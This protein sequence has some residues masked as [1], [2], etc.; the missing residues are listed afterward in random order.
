[1]RKK[2]KIK[3]FFIGLIS[4]IVFLI[5]LGGISAI[6][7]NSYFLRM[8]PI[9]NLDW[10]LLVLT[11][12]LGGLYVGLYYYIKS[13]KNKGVSCATSGGIL[14]FLAFA[15]PVCNK[16]ILLIL[17]FSGAMTYFAP[18]QPLLGVLGVALLVYANYSLYR[19]IKNG[20]N[21]K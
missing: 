17:G 20:R 10:I 13:N 11:S 7:P 18:I 19:V 9:T 15:C 1:M 8:T 2:E 21:K 16:L 4:G 6:L 5:L 3:S 14:S 12:I